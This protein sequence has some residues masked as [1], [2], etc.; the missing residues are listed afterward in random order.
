MPS[1]T[2]IILIASLA[3]NAALLGIVGGQLLSKKPMPQLD[4]PRY[5]PASDVVTAAWEQLPAADRAEL[6]TQLKERWKAMDG[7]R[8]QLSAA[9]KAVYDAALAEPFDEAKLRDAVT[10]FQ[11]REQRMQ[12]SAEDILISHIG[13]MPPEAR[14]TAAVGLL[15]PFNARMQRAGGPKRD[16]EGKLGGPP[17]NGPLAP[18]AAGTPPAA[19]H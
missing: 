17:R 14:A 9:G 5:M 12:Q 10:I 7:D 2:S 15:T 13:K 16:G 8:K 4:V 3:V 19:P 11:Q 6:G 1:R 18:G